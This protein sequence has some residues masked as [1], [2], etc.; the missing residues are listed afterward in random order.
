MMTWRSRSNPRL[1]PKPI[2]YDDMRNEDTFEHGP[3]GV[4]NNSVL[5]RNDHPNIPERGGIIGREGNHDMMTFDGNG[6]IGSLFSLG[7]FENLGHASLSS[8]LSIEHDS[9]NNN[10]SSTG[11]IQLNTSHGILLEGSFQKLQN[12]SSS[13][14]NSWK[15]RGTGRHRSSSNSSGS[16][17]SGAVQRVLAQDKNDDGLVIVPTQRLS[18]SKH[19]VPNSI[20]KRR[21]RLVRFCNKALGEYI[22]DTASILPQVTI[23]PNISR[24]EYTPAEMAASFWTREEYISQGTMRAEF[25]QQITNKKDLVVLVDSLFRTAEK[26]AKAVLMEK[27]LGM[28]G[29]PTDD[30]NEK[31]LLYDIKAIRNLLKHPKR[32][33]EPLEE[34]LR[35]LNRFDVQGLEHSITSLSEYCLQGRRSSLKVLSAKTMFIKTMIPSIVFS[36]GNSSN[37]YSGTMNAAQRSRQVVLEISQK[38]YDNRSKRLSSKVQQRRRTTDWDAITSEI[39]AMYQQASLASVLYARFHGYADEIALV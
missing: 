15:G 28:S 21:Q 13:L 9:G 25:V 31:V 17:T 7:A 22:D 24:D 2:S 5:P 20:A 16:K 1:L 37:K 6:S 29:S 10:A 4:E 26:A 32:H 18:S 39:A 30:G 33:C 8:M 35:H 23:Y 27:A 36:G 3:D 14:S 11:S 38:H 12:S 19:S 34:I